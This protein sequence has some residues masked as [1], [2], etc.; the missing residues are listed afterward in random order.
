MDQLDFL[1]KVGLDPQQINVVC[2]EDSS[3]TV[4]LSKLSYFA[5]LNTQPERMQRH[6]ATMEATVGVMY[7]DAF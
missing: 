4:R 6:G 1:R 3:Q 5:F 2:E 7:L